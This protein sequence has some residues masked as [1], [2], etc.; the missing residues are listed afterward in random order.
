M[1]DRTNLITGVFLILSSLGVF[2]EIFRAKK[3]DK[4]Y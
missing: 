1:D 4:R 3:A 2:F